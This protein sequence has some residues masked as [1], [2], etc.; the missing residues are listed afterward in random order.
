MTGKH[1]IICLLVLYMAI[2]IRVQIGD[3]FQKPNMWNGYNPEC[4]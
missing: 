4:D 3:Y 2:T 1:L